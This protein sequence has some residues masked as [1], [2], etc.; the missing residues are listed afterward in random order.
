MR[1][2]KLNEIQKYRASYIDLQSLY[3][4]KYVDTLRKFHYNSTVENQDQGI[5]VQ[6]VLFCGFRN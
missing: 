5:S 3:K 6:T 2:E 1:H 4:N